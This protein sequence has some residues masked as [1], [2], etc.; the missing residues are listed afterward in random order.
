MTTLDI[1]ITVAS[2]TLACVW[3]ILFRKTLKKETEI[4]D[5]KKA[6]DEH[7]TALEQ[8]A[9]NLYNKEESLK[10][11][12]A[13]LK[14][15]EQSITAKMVELNERAQALAKKGHELE[16]L[17]EDLAKREAAF[18]AKIGPIKEGVDAIVNRCEKAKQ[19]EAKIAREKKTK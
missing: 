14:D 13:K 6:L 3:F 11:K 17:A 16:E 1:I 8:K 2:I 5:E 7:Y 15:R 10:E 12:E 19:R 9:T 18:N 4:Q